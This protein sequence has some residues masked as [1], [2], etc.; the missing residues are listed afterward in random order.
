MYLYA[1]LHI[2]IA[3][4]I[5]TERCSKMYKVKFIIYENDKNV[6]GHFKVNKCRPTVLNGRC[7]A[8]RTHKS[9]AVGEFRTHFAYKMSRYRTTLNLHT[10][11]IL[12]N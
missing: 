11:N 10:Q 9:M 1:Y 7:D 4:L 3:P 2:F 5:S 6:I 8:E 12:Y